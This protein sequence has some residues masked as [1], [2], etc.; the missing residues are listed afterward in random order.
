VELHPSRRDAAMR[1]VV[2]FAV[3]AAVVLLVSNLTSSG[4]VRAD[5]SPCVDCGVNSNPGAESYEGALLIPNGSNARPPGLGTEAATCAG[6]TW[7]LRPDCRDAAGT[8]DAM[9]PGALG[10]CP[11]GKIRILLSLK[12]DTWPNFRDVGTFCRGPGEA[13]TPE[14]LIPGVRDQFVRFLPKLHPSFQPNGRGIVNLPVLFATGQPGSLGKH[15]FALGGFGIVLDAQTTWH[16][17]FGD[18][19]AADFT[20][21]GGPYPDTSVEHTYQRQEVCR[22]LVT[23]TWH[24]EFWVD[25]AGPF[26]V[27][28]PLITQTATLTVP[29]KEARAVLVGSTAFSGSN[30][31][32][33]PG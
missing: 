10:T 8:G 13:L 21:P 24:G 5:D 26:E 29:V 23:A 22:A 20:A 27:T 4:P 31:L 15:A 25:G 33:R 14:Q 2:T 32:P 9:C 19:S 11:R 6:C 17:E 12:R 18:G 7:L 16:W 3:V 30:A 1:R 28:G